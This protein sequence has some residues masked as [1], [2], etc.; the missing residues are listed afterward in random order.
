LLALAGGLA[1][2]LRAGRQPKGRQNSMNDH[3][4]LDQIDALLVE[5]KK[6]VYRRAGQFSSAYQSEVSTMDPQDGSL[7][8]AVLLATVPGCWGPLTAG[9]KGLVKRVKQLR[10]G[11]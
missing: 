5:V 7:A 2:R 3:Q 9:Q 11:E 1:T 10:I 4:F 8:K 6:K